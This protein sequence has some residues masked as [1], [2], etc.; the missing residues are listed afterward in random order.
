MGPSTGAARQ[1]SEYLLETVYRLH[2]PTCTPAEQVRFLSDAGAVRSQFSSR[3]ITGL[4]CVGASNL[5][6][7]AFDGRLPVTIGSTALNFPY[8]FRVQPGALVAF[9]RDMM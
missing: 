9:R 1:V 5:L 4:R 8:H 6:P 7:K 3:T 2:L